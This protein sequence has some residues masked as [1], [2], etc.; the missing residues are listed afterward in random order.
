MRGASSPS[1]ISVKLMVQ[2]RGA[3]DE[4]L[5]CRHA[6]SH[7][8]EDKRW[9]LENEKI[10]LQACGHFPLTCHAERLSL[11]TS[12]VMNGIHTSISMQLTHVADSGG[13]AGTRSSISC[14]T[15]D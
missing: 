10:A 8:Q 5:S 3:A 1:D 15:F 6:N 14:R 7:G 13:V 4:I 9:E 12:G 11:S 2:P